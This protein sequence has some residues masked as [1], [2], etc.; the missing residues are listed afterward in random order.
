METNGMVQRVTIIPG[1]AIACAWIGPTLDNAELLFI[2]RDGSETDAEGAFSN[3]MVDALV[4]A[5]VADRAVTA[6]HSN[7]DARIAS[8]RIEAI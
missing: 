1:P 3:S 8:V 7:N 6:I 4:S 2:L 5:S